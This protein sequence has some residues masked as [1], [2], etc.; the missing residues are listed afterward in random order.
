MFGHNVRD[1]LAMIC[2]V[3]ARHG[4]IDLWS[5]ASLRIPKS[6]LILV[7]PRFG[8]HCLPRSL[9]GDQMLITDLNGTLVEG[10]GT[11]PIQFA[12]DLAV[13][14]SNSSRNACI[15]AAPATAM[16]AAIARVPLRPLTHMESIVAFGQQV[17]DSAV[18]ATD[19]AAAK[20]LADKL[21]VATAVDQPGI[22][23]WATGK[24]I[25]DAFTTIYHL[26]YLAQANLVGV[27]LPHGAVATEADSDKMWSQFA[28]HA[29]YEEFFH[30]LDPGPIDHPYLKF[31]AQ[32]NAD[33]SEINGIKAAVSFSCR[34]LWERE[35]LVAFLEHVSYRMPGENRFVITA[36]KNFSEIEPGDLCVLDY[37]GN[38]ID[39]PKPPGFKW[40]HAQLMVERRD[41]IAVVHTHDLFGRTYALSGRKLEPIA[42]V[43]VDIATRPMPIYPRLD[44]IVDADVRRATIDALGDGPIVHEACHGTDF[45]ADTLERA[46]VDAIQRES[47]L[48]MDHTAKRFGEPQPLRVPLDDIRKHDASADDWWWFYTAEVGAPRRSA[49]G[50]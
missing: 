3:L 23:A 46:T 40:F 42:R 39:G 49:A 24:D 43:G 18:L 1:D 33:A 37:D 2:R 30:S 41:T 26:E 28:G 50:L 7:T 22:G 35:T 11:L 29:H 4:I 34:A 6:N 44:L 27:E 31:R 36:A 16:A 21:I 8:R 45:L 20:A 48:T 14:Q 19:T 13:Y 15:F 9:T 12:A 38:W 5:H 25:F 32:H 47:F 17:W 10:K